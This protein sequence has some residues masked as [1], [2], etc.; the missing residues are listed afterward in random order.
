MRIKHV[1][2][3]EIGDALDADVTAQDIEEPPS[4]EQGDYA[5]P[6]MGVAD[7]PRDAA[8]AAGEELAEVAPVDRVEVAGP[9]YLN[10]FLDR[11]AFADQVAKMLSDST[12]G[13]EQQSGKMLI[14]F[15]QPNIAKPM[16]VGHL[17]NNC[18]G[19]AL[20][21]IMRFCGYDVT[22]D[23]YIGDVGTQFGK[24]IYGHRNFDVDA[25]FDTEPMEYML[26]IYVKFHEKVE[27]TP[28]IEEEAAEW[29]KKIEEGDEEAVELWEKFREASIEYQKEEY[30]RL[31]VEFDRISGE[32]TVMEESRQLILELVEEGVLDRDED[33]SVFY[34]FDEEDLPGTVLLRSDGA[35]LYLTRDIY[36]LKKR[37][38]EGFDYNLYV[39]ASEQ[40]LHFKQLFQIAED[41]GIAGEGFQSEHLSYGML[42][43]PDGSMSTREGRVVRQSDV[44][45]EA[46]ERASEK[47]EEGLERTVTAAEKIGIG[48]VKYAVLE[49]SRNKDIEFDWD[50]VLSFEG[51]SGPY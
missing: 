38:E 17:R 11:A 51:D 8:E 45:D 1:L 29:T 30:E 43:L 5:F 3:E 26:D 35:T 40:E 18:L 34:E 13:V 47:A 7:N 16:H 12:M 28:E 42:S 9:G 31:G 46:V 14:E 25:S 50:R 27:E 10:V 21:R 41:L 33:G 39:V 49:V 36:N 37:K 2:A 24:V 23:N 22:S 48:A 15:S 44:L 20:Q 19:D 6:V 4:M 32:S